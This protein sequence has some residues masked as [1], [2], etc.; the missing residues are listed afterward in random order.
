MFDLHFFSNFAAQFQRSLP[1]G[2]DG[3]TDLQSEWKVNSEQW[4][5][6]SEQWTAQ[7]SWGDPSLQSEWRNYWHSSGRH[8]RESRS[9]AE[10]E[11]RYHRDGLRILP[12]RTENVTESRGK[13]RRYLAFDSVI[14][15]GWLSNIWPE[16]QKHSRQNSETF[17]A[18]LSNISGEV[19]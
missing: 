16:N 5:V 14:F 15:G 10:L 7:G 6:N 18:K 4:I 19:L 1:G 2:A 3:L 17:Q 11:Q 8:L 12:R 9:I 13:T